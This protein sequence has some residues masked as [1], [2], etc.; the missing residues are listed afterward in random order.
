MNKKQIE[1]I[2][3]TLTFCISY[4]SNVMMASVLIFIAWHGPS[5]KVVISAP[6]GEAPFELALACFAAV[7]MIYQKSREMLR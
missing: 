4:T 5:F 3:D 2:L 1:G 7:W 6:F